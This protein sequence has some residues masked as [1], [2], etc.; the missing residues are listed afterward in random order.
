MAVKPAIA[1]GEQERAARWSR[2]AVAGVVASALAY[3]T[4]VYWA[5]AR[6]VAQLAGSYPWTLFAAA[7]LLSLANYGCR[8]WRWHWLLGRVSVALDLRSSLAIFCSGLTM[9][10]SPGKVGEAGK[11]ALVGRRAPS[12]KAA[13]ATVVVVERIS[14]V[15]AVM[16][17]SLTSLAGGGGGH[18]VEASFPM[19]LPIALL[20]GRLGTFTTRAREFLGASALSLRQMLRGR[21]L[22]VVLG[23]GLV[24]WWCECVGLWVLL[25]GFGATTSMAEA[26]FAYATATLVGAIALLPGGLIAVEGSLVVLLLALELSQPVAAGATLLCRVA[27][28]WFAVA[29]GAAGYALAR[30]GEAL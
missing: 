6:N 3:A 22:A 15:L 20:V 26:T 23:L 13:V 24:A 17:L 14:D 25:R 9:A 27:T 18:I 30:R 21:G 5:D 10:I 12:T 4:L 11:I 29:V 28:L 8:F 16:L 19:V 1:S 2:A 7:L